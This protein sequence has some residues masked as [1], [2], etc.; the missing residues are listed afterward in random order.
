M[1]AFFFFSLCLTMLYAASP[2]TL[3]EADK[4]YKQKDYAHAVELYRALADTNNT[5][6]IR[7]LG[8]MYEKG[9]GVKTDAAK[10]MH[11]YKTAAANGSLDG[12]FNVGLLYQNAVGIPRDLNA[13][14]TYYTHAADLG[15]TRAQHN[16]A[17]IYDESKP[18]YTDDKKAFHYYTLAADHGFALSIAQLANFYALGRGCDRNDTKAVALYKKALSME[19]NSRAQYNVAL[20]IARGL[21]TERNA[22]LAYALWDANAQLGDEDSGYNRDVLKKRMDPIDIS[23]AQELA[24]NR[25]KMIEM[26]S[27]K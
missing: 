25:K 19:D 22:V 3:Q 1:R 12:Y 9:Q 11:Y 14:I 16:L 2:A 7:Q 27:P 10:A 23:K 15:H 18:P 13:S 17:L 5:A 8:I 24:K 21:G 4:A 20:M 26:I 6:A